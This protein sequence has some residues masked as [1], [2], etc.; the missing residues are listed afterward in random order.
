MPSET[1]Q[2]EG[3]GYGSRELDDSNELDIRHKGES[4]PNLQIHTG[5]QVGE[6]GERCLYVVNM[7]KT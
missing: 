7:I 6:R 4:R 5:A 1:V 2:V 3:H